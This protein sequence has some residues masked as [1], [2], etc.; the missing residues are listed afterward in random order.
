MVFKSPYPSLE[1]PKT[2]VLSYLFPENSTPSSEPLWIDSDDDRI[3]LSPRQMLQWVKRV[4]MGLQ[5]LGLQ[6]G[7]VVMMCTPN[8]IFVPVAYLGIVSVGCIFSGANPAYT[9]PGS[10]CFLNYA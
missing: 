1:I 9:V 10:L 2:N 8:Q 4:G 5:K 7:D 3:N 6:N